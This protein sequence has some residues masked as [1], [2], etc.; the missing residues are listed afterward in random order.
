VKLKLLT[1]SV[2]GKVA[3]DVLVKSN[4]PKHPNLVLT[5]EAEIVDQQ[6]ENKTV[7]DSKHDADRIEDKNDDLLKVQDNVNEIK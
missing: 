2:S 6:N 5:L 3:K 4:D 7:S 1:D